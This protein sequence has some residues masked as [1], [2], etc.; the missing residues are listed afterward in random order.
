M[1]DLGF[2]FPCPLSVARGKNPQFS[3]HFGI[4]RIP[5]EPLELVGLAP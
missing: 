1:T 5:R 3:G 4:T 2:L